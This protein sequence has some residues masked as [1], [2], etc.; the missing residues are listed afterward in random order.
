[1]FDGTYNRDGLALLT[2]TLEHNE[3]VSG[4]KEC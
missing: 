4:V 3:A 1:M 2:M